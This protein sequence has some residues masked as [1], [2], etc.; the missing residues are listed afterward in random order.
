MKH[1][2]RGP[3]KGKTDPLQSAQ[4]LQGGLAPNAPRCTAKSKRSGQLCRNPA[5]MGGYVCRMH[6]GSCPQVKAKAQERLM[7]LQPKAIQTLDK[8]LSRDEFPTVQLGAAKDV[9]D[10]TEG[11]ASESVSVELSGSVDIVA[12]L[13]SRHARHQRLE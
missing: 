5:I 9:L 6:G 3:V 2:P 11:R 1:A 13:Q 10:R 8:L 7:A 12:I 4:A